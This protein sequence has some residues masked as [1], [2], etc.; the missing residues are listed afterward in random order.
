[1]NFLSNI[2][3]LGH[4]LASFASTEQQFCKPLLTLLRKANSFGSWSVSGRL[5]WWKVCPYGY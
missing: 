3:N 4:A 1:M 2:V 5:F